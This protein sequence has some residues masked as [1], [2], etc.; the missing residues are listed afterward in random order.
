MLN[1]TSLPN[2]L[3]R[4][5]KYNLRPRQTR[6]VALRKAPAELDLSK[7]LER[8]PNHP[9]LTAQSLLSITDKT[10]GLRAVRAQT[11]LLKK[12]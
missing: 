8:K 6:T 9:D 2:L 4:E 10:Q 11:D 7:R 1:N 12:Q 3:R 5:G